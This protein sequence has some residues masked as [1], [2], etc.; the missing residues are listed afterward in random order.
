MSHQIYFL[1]HYER[2]Y[3]LYKKNFLSMTTIFSWI[4][5]EVPKKRFQ[6]FPSLTKELIN[7]FNHREVCFS[8]EPLT[9][10][11]IIASNATKR[12]KMKKGQKTC[13]ST[14]RMSEN[15][16][17]YLQQFQDVFLLSFK[18]DHSS[19]LHHWDMCILWQNVRIVTK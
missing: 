17:S 18:K 6:K 12:T 11:Q 14:K 5:F 8:Q 13:F 7:G 9:A 15:T 16:I 1:L 2:L 19:F 4:K 10:S 3:L